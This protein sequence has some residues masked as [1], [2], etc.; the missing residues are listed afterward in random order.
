RKPLVEKLRCD[1]INSSIERLKVLLEEELRRLQPSSRL[2]KADVLEAAVSY[3]RQQGRR[4]EPAFAHRNPEQD[5]NSGYLGCL[6]EAL[7][8]LSY[9]E[10][11]EE[12]RAQLVKHLCEVQTGPAAPRSCA[13][14]S[15]PRAPRP[16]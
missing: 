9:H 11:K 8:F 4:Q 15:R 14:R 16:R 13:P 12:T 10:P 6:K 1:R 3:L 7:R 5:F 2:D